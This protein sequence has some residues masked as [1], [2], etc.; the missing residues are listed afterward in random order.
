MNNLRQPAKR[1]NDIE[2]NMIGFA[3]L[4]N[5]EPKYI[6]F[7]KFSA[8]VIWQ[9]TFNSVTDV[10][11]ATRKFSSQQLIRNFCPFIFFPHSHSLL[12]VIT[13]KFAYRFY[14]TANV[15]I[16]SDTLIFSLEPLFLFFDFVENVRLSWFCDFLLPSPSEP[17]THQPTPLLF[18]KTIY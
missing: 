5:S 2:K 1:K 11:Q 16:V 17:Q 10:C 4:L 9:V 6:I 15:L 12:L 18:W 13:S 8:R 7:Q 3:E 14:I